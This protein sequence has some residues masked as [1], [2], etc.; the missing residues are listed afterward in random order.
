MSDYYHNIEEDLSFGMIKGDKVL[1]HVQQ[2]RKR[3]EELEA[4]LAK[5]T[6]ALEEIARPKTGPDADWTKPEIYKWRAGWY[7]RHEERARATI[8]EL[9]G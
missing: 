2:Q 7:L 5:A 3:I 9:K 1:K 8:A 4:Q 6:E